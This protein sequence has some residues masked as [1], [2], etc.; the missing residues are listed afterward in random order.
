[1]SSVALEGENNPSSHLVYLSLGL[2]L[3][4]FYPNFIEF[5]TQITKI[6]LF[7]KSTLFYGEI[8]LVGLFVFWICE[9]TNLG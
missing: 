7:N 5:Q 6:T 3:K 1:M 4:S 8:F 2:R 9:N